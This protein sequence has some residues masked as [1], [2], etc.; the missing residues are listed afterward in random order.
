M[1]KI[2]RDISRRHK[3]KRKEE[4][5]KEMEISIG[6]KIEEIKIENI[7]Y[8]DMNSFTSGE[9]ERVKEQQEHF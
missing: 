2:Y 9:L 5:L 4:I 8:D 1:V 3:F 6:R 7:S